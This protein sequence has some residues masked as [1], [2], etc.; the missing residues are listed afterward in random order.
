MQ[1]WQNCSFYEL[2]MYAI[3]LTSQQQWSKWTNLCRDWEVQGGYVGNDLTVDWQGLMMM[4]VIII[5]PNFLFI[6]IVLLLLFI[7]SLFI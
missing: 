3:T 7:S 4:I 6:L 5:L 1:C 2:K